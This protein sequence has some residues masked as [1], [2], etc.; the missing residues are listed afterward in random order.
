MWP[1]P[2]ESVHILWASSDGQTLYGIDS[3]GRFLKST[4]GGRAWSHRG[5]I[6]LQAAGSVRAF[7]RAGTFL[8]LKDGVTMLSFRLWDA[9]GIP[10]RIARSTDE[11][12]T[13]TD[14]DVTTLMASGLEVTSNRGG[15]MGPTSWVED[16]ITGYVYYGEYDWTGTQTEV[17]VYRS[18]DKGATWAKFHTFPGPATSHADKVR[19]IH[20]VE[21]DHVSQRVMVAVGDSSPAAGIYRVNAAGTAMEPWLLNRQVANQAS[22]EAARAIGL[23]PFTDYLAYVG[24]ASTFN[25]VARVPRAALD[26]TGTT[27]VDVE[28][29]YQLN[30]TGW[31]AA[32]ASSDGSRWVFSASQENNAVRIDKATHLYA[33]EDQGATVYE[34]G[35]LPVTA[36]GFASIAP[37][38]HA[39]SGGDIFYLQT[40]GTIRWAVWRC[41]LAQGTAPM[42]WPEVENAPSAWAWQTISIPYT[43]LEAGGRILMGVVEVPLGARLMRVWDMGVKGTTGAVA[44]LRVRLKTNNNITIHDTSVRSERLSR[45]LGPSGRHAFQYNMSPGNEI[46]IELENIHA[47]LSAGGVAHVTF[48]WN[49]YY[50]AGG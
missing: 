48:G 45:N 39:Q 23:I 25:Y 21:W 42:P 28:A 8:R 11:G 15:P 17:N 26:N 9:S 33:V 40:N 49:S 4:D 36:T 1:N 18:T 19:H 32:K 20:A 41:T 38:S 43:S 14:I 30:S 7:G 13:W 35:A 29:V 46:F 37:V 27:P 3:D 16:P 12:A 24:D 31:F 5:Q 50:A 10:F 22:A 47:T 44:S 2:L 34:V 6:P